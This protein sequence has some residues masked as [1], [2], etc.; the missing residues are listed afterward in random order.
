[1]SENIEKSTEYIGYGQLARILNR[2]HLS[3]F[4]FGKKFKTY[5]ARFTF[6]QYK[7]KFGERDD[8]IYIVS[9]PKS[10]TTLMQM[11]VYQMTTDGSMDFEHI[12]EVSPWTRNA[13]HNGEPVPNLPSPRIIKSH[14]FY[15][16]FKKKPKGKFIFVYRNG[17]DTAVSFFHQNK[18]YNNPDEKFDKYIQN[19]MKPSKKN[20]FN[21]CKA[22]FQ[23]K[24]KFPILYVRYEDLMKDKTSEIHRIAEFCNIPINDEI[25]NRTLERSSF[26]FMKLH[27][28]K[29]GEQP[30][31]KKE[32]VYDQFIRK[33]EVGKGKTEF[34]EEATKQF[35]KSYNK[36][37]QKLEKK[38][39]PN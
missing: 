25:I 8:D 12:Y 20:W 37:V 31:K 28:K 19:F 36:H 27:E 1:M 22:W 10:G 26:E 38:I 13:S 15:Y 24:K 18:S 32:K 5:A 6:E 2:I 14:D 7:M 17:M 33:G 39:F 21:F 23:N 3:I 11:I 16:Y 30:K 34:S 29:F 9:Y 35:L 4:K